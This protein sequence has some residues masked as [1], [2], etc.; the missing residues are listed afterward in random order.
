MTRPYSAIIL[1]CFAGAL[2]AVSVFAQATGQLTGSVSDA[3]QAAVP[4]AEVTATGIGTGLERKTTTNQQ[5]DYTLPFLP[6]GEYRVRVQ[7]EGF[8]Q[9]SRDV[10]LEVNQVARVDFALEVGEVTETV[11]VTGAAPLIESDTSA[12]GQ[13]IEGKAI[14]DLPL[15]GRNFVQLAILGPGVVG[16]GFGAAGTIMSGTRPDDLRP[17]SELFSNGNREGANNFLMD[18]GGQQ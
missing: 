4:G 17:G 18:R 2:L 1:S 14:E 12:I 6:P 5:G 15:N 3:S 13:V 10:R 9:V 11:Q 7:K 8:R 16:V